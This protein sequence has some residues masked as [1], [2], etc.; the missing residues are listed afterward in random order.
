MTLVTTQISGTAF[1]KGD[2]LTAGQMRQAIE[3]CVRIVASTFPPAFTSSSFVQ[4]ARLFISLLLARHTFANDPLEILNLALN[5]VDLLHSDPVNPQG[6]EAPI[7][8]ALDIHLYSLTGLTLLELIDCEDVGLVKPSQDAL[9]KLEYNLEQISERAHTYKQQGLHEGQ[10]EDTDHLHWADALL[11]VIIAKRET[12]QE[13]GGSQGVAEE[14]DAVDEARNDQEDT[15]VDG[16]AQGENQGEI[17]G[18]TQGV[19]QG[20]TQGETQ[21]D[22]QGE[23]QGETQG[24]TQGDTQARESFQVISAHQQYLINRLTN[25]AA[26]QESMRTSGTRVMVVDFSL[27]TRRGY[28]NVLAD[29][30]GF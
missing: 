30:N 23:T 14:A 27:L 9:S 28:L 1:A 2:S 3:T 4:E 13:E 17:Q 5:L 18:E 22:T 7:T 11:R 24:G 16:N 15:P 26:V 19:T 10:P 29:L 25:V 12:E 20:E 8:R 6:H 21:G